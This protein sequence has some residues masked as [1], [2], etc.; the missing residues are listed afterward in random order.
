MKTLELPLSSIKPPSSSIILSGTDSRLHG[1]FLSLP[2]ILQE[3][4]TEENI[5]DNAN[6]EP[7]QMRFAEAV[8]E[9]E[10][11]IWPWIKELALK[12]KEEW[13]TEPEFK[14]A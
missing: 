2:K 13:E 4:I 12:W 10:E 5:L 6:W 8:I 7:A 9:N 11:D 14:A 3:E 1:D